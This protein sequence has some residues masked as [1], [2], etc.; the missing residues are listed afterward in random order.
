MLFAGDHMASLD[1]KDAY[2]SV[3]IVWPHRKYFRFLWQFEL[4]EFTC[5]PFG[6]SLAPLAFTKINIFKSIMPILGCL[7]LEYLYTLITFC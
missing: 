4:Y 6:Y 3:P 2:F 1:L 5:L 7:V